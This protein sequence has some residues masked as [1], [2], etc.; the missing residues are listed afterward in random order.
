MTC[1]GMQES[2]SSNSFLSMRAPS[3]RIFREQSLSNIARKDASNKTGLKSI[4]SS[5]LVK[6]QKLVTQ[7]FLVMSRELNP[8]PLLSKKRMMK[9]VL[10]QSNLVQSSFSPLLPKTIQSSSQQ[11][12]QILE[13]DL[14][15]KFNLLDTKLLEFRLLSKRLRKHLFQAVRS[16]KL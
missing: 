6:C 2:S 3:V 8:L 9:T 1:M 5:A 15:V 4:N 12:K 13:K 16:K 7:S 14:M 10:L 11:E